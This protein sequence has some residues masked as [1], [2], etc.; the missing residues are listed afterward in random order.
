MTGSRSRGDPAEVANL[1]FGEIEIG[2]AF[3]L[4]RACSQQD[5][6]AFAALSGDYSPLHVYYGYARGTEFGQ[7]VVYG[8]LIASLFSNQVGMHIPGRPAFIDERPSAHA[9]VIGKKPSHV[10]DFVSS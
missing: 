5:V 1:S 10:D 8:M 4:T 9:M 7:R 2:D 6:D 3:E